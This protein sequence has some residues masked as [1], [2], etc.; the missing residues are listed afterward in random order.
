MRCSLAAVTLV[1][2]LLVA[3]GGEAT[4]TP[5]PEATPTVTEL[6]TAYLKAASAANKATDAA[7]ATWEKSKQTLTDAKRLAK[8][9]SK[10]QLTFIRAVQKIP[11][12]GDFKPIARRLLTYANQ[13]YVLLRDAMY[14]TAWLDFYGTMADLEK[15]SDKRA[16][17]SNELR[18]ALGLPPAPIK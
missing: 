5:T 11:W 1:A 16:G 4:P 18:I 2:V 10:A 7:S 13:E 8:A 17:A 3:C 14:A 6:A 9:W 15:V 12:Y